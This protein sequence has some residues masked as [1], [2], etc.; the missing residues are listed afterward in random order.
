MSN[1]ALLFGI[2]CAP[3]NSGSKRGNNRPAFA[4]LD[5][6]IVH[7][8]TDFFF[9]L[10]FLYCRCSAVARDGVE[11][12]VRSIAQESKKPT[13]DADAGRSAYHN[14]DEEGSL[15]GLATYVCRRAS[16]RMRLGDNSTILRPGAC[17]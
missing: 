16:N 14:E 3:A 5:F 1:E 4:A 17:P 12:K 7:G 15:S 9:I 10:L 13:S 11:V 6:R 8:M 2:V